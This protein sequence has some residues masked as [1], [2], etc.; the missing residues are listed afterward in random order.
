MPVKSTGHDKLHV[1]VLLTARSD[2]FKCRPFVLLKN[3]RP[4]TEITEKFKNKLYLSWCGRTFFNDKLM[5]E[6][7]NII[8]G[9]SFVGKRL[10]SWDAYRCHISEAT[11]KTLNHLKID[12]AVIPGGTTK[13]IQVSFL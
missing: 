1:T 3:K 7:L 13:F 12:T 10:L 5:S 11:K 2:G 8:M 6:Y 4:I 9:F